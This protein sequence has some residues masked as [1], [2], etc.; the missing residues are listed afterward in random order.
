MK[1]S[2]DCCAITLPND[3]SRNDEISCFK[4]DR[5]AEGGLHILNERMANLHAD[6]DE[7]EA[8]PFDTNDSDDVK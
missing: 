1:K 5:P 4:E 7:E 8:D 2:L 6:M 3:G